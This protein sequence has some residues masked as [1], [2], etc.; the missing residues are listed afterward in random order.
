MSDRKL[1]VHMTEIGRGVAV[2]GAQFVVAHDEL[3]VLAVVQ[4]WGTYFYRLPAKEAMA[5]AAALVQAAEG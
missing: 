5:L 4:S 2:D 1:P 3:I